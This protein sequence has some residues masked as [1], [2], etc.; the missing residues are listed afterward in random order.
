MWLIRYCIHVHIERIVRSWLSIYIYL[1]VQKQ[2][3]QGSL[4]KALR[5]VKLV[6]PERGRPKGWAKVGGDVPRRSVSPWDPYQLSPVPQYF[7]YRHRVSAYI[8][9]CAS[10]EKWWMWQMLRSKCQHQA[11]QGSTRHQA[12]DGMHQAI[13]MYR[14]GYE[15]RPASISTAVG[16]AAQ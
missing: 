4:D 2:S 12:S 11:V 1:G 9:Q 3:R 16:Q 10:A 8:L 14:P 6:S 7:H 15:S 5:G 13:Y